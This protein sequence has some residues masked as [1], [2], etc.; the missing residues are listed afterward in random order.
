MLLTRLPPGYISLTNQIRTAV[1]ALPGRSRSWRG[2]RWPVRCVRYSSTAVRYLWRYVSINLVA[3][4]VLCRILGILFS[5][6]FL[7]NE[8]IQKSDTTLPSAGSRSFLFP[9]IF[10]SH[11]VN[12]EFAPF[13]ACLLLCLREHA[14]FPACSGMR[15]GR[16]MFTKILI[17]YV[18]K[19]IYPEWDKGIDFGWFR[20]E[21]SVW[22]TRL[23]TRRGCRV[24]LS[25]SKY[26]RGEC[27]SLS[28]KRPRMYWYHETAVSVASL[29]CIP[30]TTFFRVL[31]FLY[32][33][34]CRRARLLHAWRITVIEEESGQMNYTTTKHT[35]VLPLY[36]VQTPH[37][38]I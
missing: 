13:S 12:T 16:T 6:F 25:N 7:I 23:G 5:F 27:R 31:A 38:Y 10:S 2:N 29:R 18:H 33:R 32:V 22:V 17:K 30:V 11:W 4:F 8:K 34:R 24:K 15:C 26:L 35:W 3:S 37:T 20:Y 36:I 1:F 28:A 14:H 9:F 19:D 21:F